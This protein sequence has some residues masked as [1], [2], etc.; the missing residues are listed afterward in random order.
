VHERFRVFTPSE[1]PQIE[2]T[3]R[4]YGIA[5]EYLLCTG[6]LQRRKNIPRL[7][8]AFYLLKQKYHLPHQLVLIGPQCP[9]LP[10]HEIFAQIA[11]L[12]L[13]REVIWTGY[14]PR[15]D[16]PGLLN[17]ASVCVQPSLY[18]G[19]GMPLLEAMACGTPVAC[20]QA[21]SFPEV[22][23]EN[24]LFFDPYDVESM[25]TTLSRILHDAD[26]QKQLRQDGLQRA[27]Q[28]SWERC[29]H[30]TLAVLDEVGY[31]E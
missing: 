18:E 12:M 3:T 31:G 24:G 9:D 29:A 7:L 13:A 1:Q 25:V 28:F 10:E 4:K 8:Q 26:L 20:S 19:F 14:I 23:G 22:V 6:T 27:R 5:R 15:D 11:R 30:A 17:G 2:A 16:L 21:S